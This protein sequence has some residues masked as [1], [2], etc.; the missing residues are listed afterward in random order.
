MICMSTPWEGNPYNGQ[1]NLHQAQAL[2]R[3]GCAVE[4]FQ[5]LVRVP[6]LLGKLKPRLR[7]MSDVPMHWTWQ[8]VSMHSIR[9]T[10]P[11][12]SFLRWKVTTKHPRLGTWPVHRA[13]TG[14]LLK[15][16]RTFKPDALHV[17]DGLLLGA[18]TRNLARNLG[19]PFS[20]IEHD[21][22]E[23]RPATTAGDYYTS[24]MQ[25]AKVVF[26]VGWPSVWDLRDV[27]GLPNVRLA[28]DGIFPASAEQ[29]A[30]PRPPEFSG[31]KLVLCAGSPIPSKGHAELVRAFI[32]LNNPAG[33]LVLVGR[34]MP[35][36][37]DLLT[38]ANLGSRVVRLEKMPVQKFQQWMVWADVFAL[39]SRLESFGMVYAEAMAAETPVILTDACGIA[40]QL[41]NRV[42]GWIV[43]VGDQLALVNALREALTTPNLQVMGEAGR[44]MAEGVFT[45]DKSARAVL[46]GLR[47][48]PVPD[49][50]EVAPPPPGWMPPARET[51]GA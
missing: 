48:D 12:P 2:I 1:Y 46:A 20:V 45:W 29:R 23:W 11:H 3:Q 36:V 42:H 28:P 34:M 27:L 21:A 5:P 26:G 6:R 51:W 15:A 38:Q 16:L 19:I 7:P 49:G 24:V 22:M 41:Q 13:F 8:G 40:P 37:E 10:C 25:D 50:L 30:T 39:P 31:K 44:K 18:M 35:Q 43:P 4:I 47:G 14:G 9:G 32:E 17:H 33:V